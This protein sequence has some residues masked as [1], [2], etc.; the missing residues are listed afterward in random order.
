[1]RPFCENHLLVERVA[2]AL[3]DA[4]LNLARGHHRMQHAAHF[5]HG[6]EVFHFGRVGHRVD[7]DLRHVDRPRIRA[8]CFAVILLIIPINARRSFIAAHG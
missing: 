7:G 3:R 1:M 2:D 5:L 4:A 8:V 6:P